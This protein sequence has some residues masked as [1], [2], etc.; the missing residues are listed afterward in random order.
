M[1]EAETAGV[2]GDFKAGYVALIG[3]PNAGKSTLLNALLGQKL[4]IVS[5]KPQTTRHRIVG[6]LNEP[7]LQVVFLDTPGVI[8]PKYLLQNVM[9]KAVHNAIRDADLVLRLVDAAADPEPA[10]ESVEDKIAARLTA[11]VILLLNKSDITTPERRAA[12]AMRASVGPRPPVKI[13]EI[14]ALQQ[15]GFASASPILSLLSLRSF[16]ML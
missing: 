8:D 15:T 16:S 9:M 14:S 7:G 5:N 6:I 2:D 12:N 3:R 4:S 13:L 1:T 10:G 11:P